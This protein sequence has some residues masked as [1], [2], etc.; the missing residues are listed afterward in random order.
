MFNGDSGLRLIAG[1][2]SCFFFLLCS[3]SCLLKGRVVAQVLPVC[4]TIPEEPRPRKSSRMWCS[5]QRN[6]QH[7]PFS[8]LFHMSAPHSS[9]CI[10]PLS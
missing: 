7:H 2:V 5:L 6:K 9:I 4:V 10:V 1:S 8:S 3:K